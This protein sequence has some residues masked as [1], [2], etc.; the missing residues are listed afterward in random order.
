MGHLTV[1]VL[2]AELLPRLIVTKYTVNVSFGI[3]QRLL[4]RSVTR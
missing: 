4:V 1:G 2:P 3:T